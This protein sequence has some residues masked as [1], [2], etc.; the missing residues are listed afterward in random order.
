MK[1]LITVLMLATALGTPTL[2]FA[3]D[4][5]LSIQMSNYWGPPAYLAVYLN[6]PDGTFDS[7]VWVAGGQSRYQRDLR[8]WFRAASSSNQR[9]DGITGASIGGGRTMQ[10]D[11]NIADS[12]I[13]AGYTLHV[14]SAVQ[15]G[16]LVRD[17]AV[18]KLTQANS[19]TVVAGRGYVGAL[20]VSF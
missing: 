11:V 1:K 10:V 7:T 13:D 18:L 4:T 5:K 6:K 15:D 9:I 14:D 2:A 20:S 3:K 19:G 16:G 8:S 12:L 17:D